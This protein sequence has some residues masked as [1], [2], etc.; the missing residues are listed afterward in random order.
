M[1]RKLASI[2][3]VDN[4]DYILA[5][6]A[7]QKFIQDTAPKQEF[8]EELFEAMIFNAAKHYNHIEDKKVRKFF[9]LQDK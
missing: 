3:L 6:N 1:E 8:P 7:I 5:L 4:F 9:G 2:V